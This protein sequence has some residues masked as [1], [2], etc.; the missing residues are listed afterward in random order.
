MTI[1]APSTADYDAIVVGARPAG[2]ATALL[3]ARRGLRVLVVDRGRYGTDTLSTHALMRAGVLQLLRFGVLPGIAEHAAPPIRSASF[4]Y[5]DDEMRV[6]VKPRDGVDALCAPR[7]TILDRAIVDVAA[8]AGVHFSYGTA[9]VDVMRES[10]GRVSGV[11]VK[12]ESGETRSLR[13]GLVIGADGARSTIAPL[14]QADVTRKAHASAATVFGYWSD[15][16]VDGYRWYFRPGL[17]AGAVPTNHG[18]TC[19]FASVP[20][21][22]FAEVFRDNPQRGYRRVLAEVAPD[23]TPAL[24]VEASAGSLRGWPGQPGYLRR[25][26]GPGWAL[27]GDAAYFKDPITA[28]GITDA[29]VEADYLS[30]AVARGT[31]EALRDYELDRD[32]RVETIFD[33]TDRIASFDWTLDEVRQLHKQLSKAMSDEVTALNTRI[34][35]ASLASVASS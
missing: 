16:P 32:R 14:V 3:L 15:V 18:L 10:G 13:A 2:A 21:R 17:S 25:A 23:L 26:A 6:P 5:G 9:V 7:R 24:R 19:V 4:I 34:G 8:D 30:D 11:V 31:D 22:R 33:V 35:D 29:L 20:S 28:H 27:V 1:E 12:R